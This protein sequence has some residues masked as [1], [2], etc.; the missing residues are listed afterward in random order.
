[1]ERE[2]NGVAPAALAHDDS[3]AAALVEN[4]LL[5][6]Q[7]E[8]AGGPLRS[9]VPALLV[10]VIE[11]AIGCLLARGRGRDETT[12]AIHAERW[13]RSRD[14]S[15][16]FAFENVCDA[17]HVDPERLR[18]TILEQVRASSSRP[19]RARRRHEVPRSRR[20]K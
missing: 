15:F 13:I 7:L 3:D 14:A 10:A 4:I 6:A 9:G 11:E 17:L 1:M 18:R 12:A 20:I 2:A 8:R 16:L 19:T 5:P